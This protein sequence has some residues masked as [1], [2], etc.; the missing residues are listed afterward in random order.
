MNQGSFV[1][2][3]VFDVL[4]RYDF[5][6]CVQKH[7]GNHRIKTLTCWEQFI[8]MTFA[9]LSYRES[10]RDIEFCLAGM[11][12]K[13][14][15]CGIRTAIARSTLAKANENRS[16]KIYEDLGQLLIKIA[17]PMHKGESKL[18]EE[19]QTIIYAFDST[20]IDLCMELFPWA[21]FRKTKSAVK[22][23]VLLNID[24]S[25]PEFISITEGKKQDVNLLDAITYT[26]GCFYL[27]D[28]AYVDFKRL[29][30]IELQKAFFVTRAKE[31]MAY[32]VT[33]TQKIVGKDGIKKDELV[34][35]KWHHGKRKY[36]IVFRRIEYVDPVTKLELNFLT[37]HLTIEAISVAQLYKERWRVELFFKWI[38]QN[39]K[40]KRF[41][42]N[43]ENAVKT[44]I[45][46][47]ICTYLLV[48]ILRKQLKL[49]VAL[50]QMMQILS[51]S[52]FE[53]CAIKELFEKEKTK[54][55]SNQ[56]Q[57]F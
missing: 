9:Q 25:I 56:P 19:L 38:K 27:V 8:V 17:L 34:Q 57:L 50:N 24:G 21:K 42:G 35:L 22:V 13:M 40:I 10:L 7:K 48:A 47:A 12:T 37:N 43:S 45:W 49:D 54:V 6:K 52:L 53:R 11:K 14:Y 3:Q 26:G 33:D 4:S 32:V 2:S 29:Y 30:K 41:Y 23:H 20:T 36:P 1:L 28:K 16:W 55:V 39:L 15:H 31:N 18:A 44:Q 51:I 5:D 46:I